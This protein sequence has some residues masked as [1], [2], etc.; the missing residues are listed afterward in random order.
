VGLSVV[1]YHPTA[2]LIL[3]VLFA[4]TVV[5]PFRLAEWVIL[6]MGILLPFYFLAA[7]LFLRDEI[8]PLSEP[9]PYLHLN[10]PAAKM[11]CMAGDIRLS[12]LAGI[13]GCRLVYWQMSVKRMVI[14]IRKNWGVMMVMLLILLP[15]PFIFINAGIES[16]FMSLL[17]IGGFCIQCILLSAAADITQYPVLAGCG[18]LVYNNWFILIK[19]SPVLTVWLVTLP[20]IFK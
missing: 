18:V 12:V 2:I 8:W 3:V 11:G 1:C 6:L 7:Y 14:Q 13:P 20:P 5:R 19:I 9:F 4:L 10:L 17:P 15:I 16:A